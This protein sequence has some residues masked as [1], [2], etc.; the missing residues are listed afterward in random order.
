MAY[1]KIKF[2]EFG[3]KITANADGSLNVPDCPYIVGI[4]GG[5]TATE[6]STLFRQIHE[7]MNARYRQLS[8]EQIGKVVQS[9]KR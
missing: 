6:Y 3:S 8:R 5:R 9:V 1:D 4:T 7:S 2:P